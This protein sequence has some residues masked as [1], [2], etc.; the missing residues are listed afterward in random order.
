MRILTE[1]CQHDVGRRETAGR[2]RKAG[3][4]CLALAI[5]R[6]RCFLGERL[7]LNR[8]IVSSDFANECHQL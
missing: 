4:T 7:P 2:T 5:P 6:S 8:W 3:H 1:V